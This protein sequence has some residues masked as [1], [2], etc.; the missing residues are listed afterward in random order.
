MKQVNIILLLTG[1]FIYSEGYSQ[2][3]PT[4][5]GTVT[6]QKTGEAL[7]GASVYFADGK[8]GAIA[9]GQ[10]KYVLRNIPA[11]HHVIE[12][13]HTGY[14]TVVEHFELKNDTIK[15]FSLSSVIVENQGVIVTGVSGATNIRKAPVPVNTLRKLALLQTASTNIVD[16]LSQVPGVSQV[17]TGPGISKP[18]IR[19][20]GYNRVVT[21]NDGVRQE[22]QQWGDE[23]GIEID[24]FGVNK[25][26]VLKG[27]ASVMYGSDAMAGVI[28]ILS[29]V[30]V[31]EGT[32]KG[33]ILGNYQMNNRLRAT[34][35]NIAGNS[36]GL[37]W[38]L[39]GSYKAAADYTNRFD[40]RVYN[41]KFKE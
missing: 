5:T 39:S 21:V 20:L 29:N 35:A 30:P 1:I 17:T 26:E 15:N 25:I 37:Y 36:N 9:D 14:S 19:G 16:A 27:P 13:S 40:G 23:H 33:S 28:N 12:V 2:L 10:G 4:F 41:S 3:K 31:Q 22:G 7:A 32:I 18:F 6:D 34:S 24:E 38:N 8:I 11:G